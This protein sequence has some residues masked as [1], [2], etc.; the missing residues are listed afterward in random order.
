[1]GY[2][3]VQNAPQWVVASAS[4]FAIVMYSLV[5]NVLRTSQAPAWLAFLA[6]LWI[7][8]IYLAVLGFTRMSVDVSPNSIDL[9]WRLGWP[10]K[11]IDRATITSFQRH[12]NSW[13][14]GWGIRKVRRGWMWNVWGLDS[15]E[16]TL[17][18]GKK[19][20]I[21]TDDTAGL[22]DALSK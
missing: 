22:I 4:L 21:G 6:I 5:I 18:S 3:R 14:E 1:M 10:R 13:I 20:R 8:V 11:S 19:F 2:Q 7:T 17:D 12:R 16:L 9:V 15:V